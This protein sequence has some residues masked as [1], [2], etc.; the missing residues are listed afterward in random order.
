MHAFFDVART[1]GAL[2]RLV[3]ALL[4]VGI[5]AAGC[6]KD[7]SPTDPTPTPNCRTWPSAYQTVLVAGATTLTTNGT[8]VFNRQTLQS[9]CT[10]DTVGPG[11]SSRVV[12]VKTYASIDEVLAEVSVVPPLTRATGVTS[13][14]TGTGAG[15]SALTYAFDGQKRLLTETSVAYSTTWSA[16]DTEGRPTTGTTVL[17][18]GAISQ[19]AI[20][21]NNATRARTTT[22]TTNGS[23]LTCADTF[24]VT[25]S[26]IATVCPSSASSTTIS[27]TTQVCR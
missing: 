26:L 18:A 10:A 12:T 11:T 15:T 5:G 17:T 25:G 24:D 4:L 20:N 2:S 8:C 1:F 9:T 13:V 7:A 3:V 16:W 21:Y 6:Q 14:T 19:V 22:T 27:S 23:S